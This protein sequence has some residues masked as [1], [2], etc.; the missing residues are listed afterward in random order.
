[1][2]LQTE[3]PRF[4]R[5]KHVFTQGTYGRRP[6]RVVNV[7]QAPVAS[8]LPKATHLLTNGFCR[9]SETFWLIPPV[10][11]PAAVGVEDRAIHRRKTLVTGFPRENPESGLWQ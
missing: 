1:V 2:G 7:W 6:E 5:N 3:A 8:S 10:P 9:C 11:R 4:H